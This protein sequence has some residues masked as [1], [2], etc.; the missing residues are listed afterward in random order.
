MSR[1][2]DDD[3]SER[4]ISMALVPIGI[5]FAVLWNLLFYSLIVRVSHLNWPNPLDWLPP[6]WARILPRWLR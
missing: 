6:D 5:V 1:E 2:Q 4:L 3:R